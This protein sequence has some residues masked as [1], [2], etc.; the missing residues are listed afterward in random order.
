MASLPP[1]GGWPERNQH[2]WDPVSTHPIGRGLTAPWSDRK[3]FLKSSITEGTALQV[4]LDFLMQSQGARSLGSY[5]SKRQGGPQLLGQWR[6]AGDAQP[7]Q[8]GNAT[9]VLPEGSILTPFSASGW[10][11]GKLPQHSQTSHFPRKIEIYTLTG[12]LL[13]K[14]WPLLWVFSNTP[15][16]MLASWNWLL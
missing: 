9:S 13:F 15:L 4:F 1:D 2:E 7:G 6:M 3:Q 5:I 11:L 14:R 16:P 8:G 10:H 12:N